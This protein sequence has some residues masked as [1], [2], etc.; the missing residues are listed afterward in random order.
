MTSFI[1][2][3]HI[4][5]IVGMA[6]FICQ[7]PEYGHLGNDINKRTNHAYNIDCIKRIKR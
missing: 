4:E 7:H 3:K 2:L 6:P 5:L 1:I